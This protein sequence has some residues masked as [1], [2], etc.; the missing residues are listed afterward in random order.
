[1]IGEADD[2]TAWLIKNRPSLETAYSC[3]LVPRPGESAA[4]NN[5]TGV[6]A[7]NIEPVEVMDAAISFP[8]GAMK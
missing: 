5:A 6:P 1:V 4:G 8:S 3:L 7:A 2:S